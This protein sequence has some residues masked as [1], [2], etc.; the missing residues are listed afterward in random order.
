MTSIPGT[1][2]QISGSQFL[3]PDGQA[4][5]PDEFVQKVKV[6][7]ISLGANSLQMISSH[8]GPDLA[9]SLEL[10]AP[11]PAAGSAV[12]GH[13]ADAEK[14]TF[15]LMAV[16]ELIAESQQKMRETESAIRDSQ[17][18]SQIASLQSAASAAH[19]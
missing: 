16:M 17:T 7:E 5:S 9:K 1:G 10:A 4:I 18:A 8:F 3:A 12:L 13:V 19:E 15:N 6:G 11:P 14:P 2:Y